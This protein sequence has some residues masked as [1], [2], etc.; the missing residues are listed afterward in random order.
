VWTGR[1]EAEFADWFR[2]E[3]MINLSLASAPATIVCTYDA[4]SVPDSVLASAP[5]THPE[6]ARAGDV[7]TSSA[8]RDPEDVLLT[9]G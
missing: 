8:D 4:R 9:P 5:R 6:V 2:Y 3:S 7:T 1:S